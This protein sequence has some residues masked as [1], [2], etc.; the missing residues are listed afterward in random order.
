MVPLPSLLPQHP[1]LWRGDQL[2]D[3]GASSVATGWAALDRELPGGGWP[4]GSVGEL[5]VNQPGRGELE[6][7][8]PALSDLTESRKQVLLISPPAIPYAPAWQQAG[9]VLERL[10]WIRPEKEEDAWWVLEQALRD[11]ACGMVLA[12]LPVSPVDRV[13]RRLRL[14][15]ET[16][17][18]TGMLLTTDTAAQGSPAALRLSVSPRQDGL[19]VRILK[20]RGPPLTHPLWL[21]RDGGKDEHVVVSPVFTSASIGSVSPRSGSMVA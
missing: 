6:L 1:G 15:A 17:G 19:E 14:A 21:P 3:R 10:H 7:L 8:W 16:S 4:A 18:A 20:R 12:W 2:P 5:C 11:R 9:I 13:H